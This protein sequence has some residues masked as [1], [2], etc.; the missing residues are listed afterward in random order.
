MPSGSEVFARTVIE[1]QP[2]AGEVVFIGGW[3]HALYLAEA[4]STER[5]VRT[6]DI[7]ITIPARLLTADRPALLDLVAAAGFEIR[8]IGEG[9]GILDIFQTGPGESVIELDLLTEAPDPH[10]TIAIEGQPGLVIQG[11]PGQHILL[12][13]ARWM[14]VDT[15]IHASLEPPK[16]IR[17]P[18]LPAYILAKGLSSGARTSMA[19][20][21]KDLVY[22]LE[23]A[24]HPGLGGLA[25]EGM[26]PLA[27]RYPAEY[28]RWRTN[29]SGVIHDRFLLAEIVGQLVEGRRATGTVQEV[30]RTVIVRLRRLLGETPVDD[31]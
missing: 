6:D 10:R 16:R 30:G 3:V 24:R 9:S 12:E 29:L 5:A 8:E 7:D 1:L 19:A 11:Y 31:E 21:A 4:N 18:T 14:K 20:R 2:Y 22:L 28:R 15:E 26:R 17:V 25:V 27:A 23:I 13:N